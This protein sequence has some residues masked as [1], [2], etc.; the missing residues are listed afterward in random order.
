[1][2]IPTRVSAFA[3]T[4]LMLA[5]VMT[6]PL[7]ALAQATAVTRA[8]WPTT[9]W[10]TA[11]PESQGMDSARLAQADARVRNELPYVTSLLVVRGGDLVFEEYYGDFTASDT[12][13]I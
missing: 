2:R 9:E 3:V 5:S 1:M 6:L 7:D 10:R 4:C 13:Q 12:V 11:T 8:Y